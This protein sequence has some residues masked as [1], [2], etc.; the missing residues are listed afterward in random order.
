MEATSV[1]LV[2]AASPHPSH[3]QVKGNVFCIILYHYNLYYFLSIFITT[4]SLQC[5]LG[6]RFT[7]AQ[8]QH[9]HTLNKA[10]GTL[11]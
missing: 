9:I 6:E 5:K 4:H 7:W 10:P 1:D 8:C 3:T 11:E 2:S